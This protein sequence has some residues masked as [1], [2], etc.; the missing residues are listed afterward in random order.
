MRI[1]PTPT[2]AAIA[3]I[4]TGVGLFVL[5]SWLL[6]PLQVGPKVGRSDEISALILFIFFFAPV[7]IGVIGVRRRSVSS[8]FW[9]EDLGYQG[10]VLKRALVWFVVV[11]AFMTISTLLRGEA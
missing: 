3:G 5:P 6:E 9:Q 10:Q 11:G 1:E 7:F 4:W 8:I 2:S